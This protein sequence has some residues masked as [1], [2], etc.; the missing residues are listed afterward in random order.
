MDNLP[1]LRTA[2]VSLVL[3][4]WLTG[5][6]PTTVDRRP[7]ARAPVARSAPPGIDGVH[8]VRI[9]LRT[10]D[11]QQVSGVLREVLD[12]PHDRDV[13]AILDEPSTDSIVVLGTDAG[14]ARVRALLSPA[15]VADA[16][17]G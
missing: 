3:A 13:R 1:A 14:I 5:C 9:T 10:R 4:A 8:A 15:L 7:E 11:A 6:S 2:S 17:E 16:P 12:L